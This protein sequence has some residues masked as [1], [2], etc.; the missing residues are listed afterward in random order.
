LTSEERQRVVQAAFTLLGEAA[1]ALKGEATVAGGAHDEDKSHVA[2]SAKAKVWMKQNGISAQALEHVFH[3]DDG[4]ATFIAG[5]LPG[6]S[7]KEKALNAYVLAGL[8][9]FL[10][11]G[12]L[13]FTDQE[14]RKPC[15]DAGCYDKNNHGTYL[16]AKGNS[17]TGS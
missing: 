17:F 2:V 1:P 4:A 15:T 3:L 11:I 13:K 5:E 16:K 12:E 7:D 9:G 8:A 10:V 14:A 6:K